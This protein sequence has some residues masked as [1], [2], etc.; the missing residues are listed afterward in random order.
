MDQK[1]NLYNDFPLKSISPIPY[2]N[3]VDTKTD[4]ISQKKKKRNKSN[5]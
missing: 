2:Y 3:F 5:I 1:L 4:K